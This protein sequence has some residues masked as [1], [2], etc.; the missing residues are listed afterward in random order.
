MHIYPRYEPTIANL[1]L[2]YVVRCLVVDEEGWVV[3]YLLHPLH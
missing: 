3:K 1:P 2:H